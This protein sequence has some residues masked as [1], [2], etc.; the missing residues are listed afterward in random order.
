MSVLCLLDDS[1]SCAA[2]RGDTRE[3]QGAGPV[4]FS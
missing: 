2:A 1:Q 3:A 4:W